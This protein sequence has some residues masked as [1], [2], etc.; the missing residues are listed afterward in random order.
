MEFGFRVRCTVDDIILCMKPIIIV[1]S[2]VGLG[3]AKQAGLD[4]IILTFIINNK[5]NK[6]L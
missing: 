4:Q 6:Y 2:L 3:L 5:R 1:G